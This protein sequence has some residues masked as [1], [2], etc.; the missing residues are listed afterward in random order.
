MKN[1]L[2]SK[3]GTPEAA[4][5]QVNARPKKLVGYY[6]IAT[7]VLREHLEG[8]SLGKNDGGRS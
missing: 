4:P 3:E 1:G 5:C 8:S 7:D 6:A 2:G